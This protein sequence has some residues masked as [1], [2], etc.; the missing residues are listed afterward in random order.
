M[1]EEVAAFRS[2]LGYALNAYERSRH[3]SL[4]LFA[5]TVELIAAS[6]TCVNTTCTGSHVFAIII[7]CVSLLACI[8]LYVLYER[9]GRM[10]SYVVGGLCMWWLLAIIVCTFNGPFTASDGAIT[11]ANGFFATWGAFLSAISL[12]SSGL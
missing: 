7:G 11:N 4:V 6:S 3:L 5:S 12:L 8:L 9:I 2:M 1:H 10:V